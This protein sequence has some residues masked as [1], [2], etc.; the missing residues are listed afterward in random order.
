MLSFG[1]LGDGDLGLFID[2]SF[3]GFNML[4]FGTLGDGYSLKGSKNKPSRH[5]HFKK[6]FKDKQ[7]ETVGKL[8]FTYQKKTGQ[9]RILSAYEVPSETLAE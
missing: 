5:T 4:S 2:E 7:L 6:S 3:S 9:P 1:T 8:C